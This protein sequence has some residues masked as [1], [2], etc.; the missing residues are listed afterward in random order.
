[1]NYKSALIVGA[2]AAALPAHAQSYYDRD[3]YSASSDVNDVD[4]VTVYAPYR[5]ERDGAT[6]A[7]IETE[8]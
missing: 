7:P 3:G 6:G 8:N 4:G 5:A 2:G 1:M